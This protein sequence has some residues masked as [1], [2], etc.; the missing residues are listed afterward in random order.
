MR[1]TVLN[2]HHKRFAGQ[3]IMFGDITEQ[4]QAT[5][6]LE[7]SEELYRTQSLE[8][9]E[10]N[11]MKELL[12]D[13]IAHDLKNPA[14]VIKGFAE[15][16][17]EN[18]PDNEILDEINSGVDSLLTIISNA[19][20]LSKVAV[21]DKIEKEKLDI[22]N[23]I[24]AVIDENSQS[25]HYEEMTLDLKVEEKLIL[26]VNPIIGDVFRNYVGNAIKYGKKGKKI[27]I[28]ATVED[29]Y[30]TVNVKDLGE[31]IKLEDR[32]NIFM[33]TVQLSKS[34]GSGL[35]LAIVKRI[36]EAHDAEVG[37]KPNKPKGNNFYIKI[38]VS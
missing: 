16:G 26:T 35:G 23:I 3:I 36:A 13:V 2:D 33:R 34:K 20:T 14:G 5:E 12:L 31:T 22:V 11:A 37:V 1:I 27:I 29:D 9:A 21:G 17:L 18:D 6:K 7:K 25:L 38:P 8:L 28:D 24:K 15:Y 4:K 30:I 10:S 32:E 19:T